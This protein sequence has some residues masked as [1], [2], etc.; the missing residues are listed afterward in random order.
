MTGVLASLAGPLASSGVSIFV[1]STYDTD[2]LMV[3]ERD[4]DRAW[5]RSSAPATPWRAE[6]GYSGAWATVPSGGAKRTS[7]SRSSV[8]EWKPCSTRAATVKR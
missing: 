4:L 6:G 3:Q 2:Y 1:V 8:I 7:S 5:T